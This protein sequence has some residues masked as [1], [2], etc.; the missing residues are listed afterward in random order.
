MFCLQQIACQTFTLFPHDITFILPVP[1]RQTAE[2]APASDRKCPGRSTFQV[3]R[4]FEL[5]HLFSKK[6]DMLKIIFASRLVGTVM[7]K[8][9]I[10]AFLPRIKKGWQLADKTF[11]DRVGTDMPRFSHCLSRGSA[12]TDIVRESGV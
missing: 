12:R 7:C 5:P 10:V 6:H 4:K 8:S 11:H 1:K 3:P 9:T 2:E